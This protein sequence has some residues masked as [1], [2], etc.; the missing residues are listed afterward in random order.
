MGNAIGLSKA[1]VVASI[2]QHKME[3]G[4]GAAVFVL[5]SSCMA[6]LSVPPPLSDPVLSAVPTT[7]VDATELAPDF[8]GLLPIALVD[9]IWIIGCS[10]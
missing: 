2:R 4:L 1:A 8:D 5:L 6:P 9:V 3:L 7:P 10:E